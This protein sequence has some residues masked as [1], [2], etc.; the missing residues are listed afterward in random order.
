MIYIIIIYIYEILCGSVH[1]AVLAPYSCIISGL[2]YEVISSSVSVV[3]TI[4]AFHVVC[5]VDFQA[6]Y[7]MRYDIPNLDLGKRR[8]QNMQ[9]IVLLLGVYS[10]YSA[11]I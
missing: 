7:D 5:A 11:Y 4:C 9:S 10:I 8:I 1:F 6:Y 2:F 3:G